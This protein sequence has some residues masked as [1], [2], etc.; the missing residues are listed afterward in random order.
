MKKWFKTGMVIILFLF[1]LLGLYLYSQQAVNEDGYM[2][3]LDTSG[4]T[5]NVDLL[6]KELE[7]ISELY[8]NS[9]S[10]IRLNCEYDNNV[11]CKIVAIVK[12]IEKLSDEDV[13]T[14]KERLAGCVGISTDN[15]LIE[16]E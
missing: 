4:D 13:A 5:E 3:I 9:I 10:S 14:I 1:A 2:E 6:K 16:Y 7:R 12:C 15:V 11:I 8:E